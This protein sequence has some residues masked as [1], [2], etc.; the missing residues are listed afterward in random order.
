MTMPVRLPRWFLQSAF[1]V[2]LVASA[3]LAFSAAP[4]WQQA[5]AADGS[6]PAGYLA[7]DGTCQD[8]NECAVNNGGC[9]LLAACT[10]TPG[11]RTCGAC[12]SGAGGSGYQGCFDVND[13]PNGDCSAQD[14][15]S[16][17]IVTSGPVAATATG[18]DGAP[19][20]FAAL[21]LDGVD[22]VRDVRCTPASGSTFPVGETRV[23]CTSSDKSGN[24]RAVSFKVTV[25]PAQ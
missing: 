25:K 4:E 18:P 24:S 20:T 22:G 19:V 7:A 2:L 1:G 14:K 15:L 16:P 8:V 13:C 23:T 10:N 11:S 21:A 6:C 12:P 5:P 17:A 9:D 3:T